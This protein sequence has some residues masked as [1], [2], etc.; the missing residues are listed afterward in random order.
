VVSALLGRIGQHRYRTNRSFERSDTGFDCRSVYVAE[1]DDGNVAAY[2]TV[3]WLP[4]LFL[5]VLEGYV[6]ELFAR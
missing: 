6:S 5:P 1:V 2:L 4:Y 3:Q